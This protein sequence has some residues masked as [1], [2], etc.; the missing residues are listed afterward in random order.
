MKKFIALIASVG[1]F[2]VGCGG[3]SSDSKPDPKNKTLSGYVID[4]PIEGAKVYLDCKEDRY[5][6]KNKTSPNGAF[7]ISYPYSVSPKGCMVYA[8]GGNDG[9]DLSDLVLKT[10]YNLQDKSKDI[11]ITPIT[12]LYVDVGK[13]KQKV[14]EFLDIQETAIAK[15]PTK[16]I[17]L[18]KAAKKLVKI[19]LLKTTDDKKITIQNVDGKKI[20]TYADSLK[21]VSDEDKQDL[22]TT[23]SSIDKASTSQEIIK[24][25]SLP[26]VILLL[27]KAYALSD[28]N[29]IQKSNIEILADKIIEA[30]KKDSKYKTVTK[31]KVR[32][33]LSDIDLIPSFE[34]NGSLKADIVVVLDKPKAVFQALMDSNTSID[35]KDVD[36]IN[37]YNT[38]KYK[39]IL[40]SNEERVQ[41]YT[42]SEKSHIAK[43]LSLIEDTYDDTL[44]NPAYVEIAKGFAKLG[45]AED[46]KKTLKESVYDE[47][48]KIRGGIGIA[49]ILIEQDK[50]TKAKEVL[51]LSYE[52]IK[53]YLVEK[54]ATYLDDKDLELI[55]DLY[56]AYY[57]ADSVETAEALMIFSEQNIIKNFTDPEH[58]TKMINTYVEVMQGLI[59]DNKA[60]DAKTIF[61][62]ATEFALKAKYDEDAP[63]DTISKL[64]YLALYGTVL[65][66][67]KTRVDQL[68][69]R[70]KEIDEKCDTGYTML[71]AKD[72]S[73]SDLNKTAGYNA[74]LIGGIMALNGDLDK[75]LHTMQTDGLLAPPFWGTTPRNQTATAMWSGVAAAMFIDGNET[76]AIN[77]IYKHRIKNQA[78]SGLTRLYMK[79]QV[80]YTLD[81]G[82]LLKIYDNAH[83]T[84]LMVSF[85][86]KLVNDI[87]GRPWVDL[88]DKDIADHVLAYQYLS[89]GLREFGLAIAIRELHE[90]GEVTKRNTIV[91]RAIKFINKMTDPI[92]KVAAYQSIINVLNEIKINQSAEFNTLLDKITKEVKNVEINATYAYSSKSSK[93]RKFEASYRRII[94]NIKYLA[95]YSTQENAKTLINKVKDAI[96][97]EDVTDLKNVMRRLHYAIGI[98]ENGADLYSSSLLATMVEAKDFESAEALI[99]KI[100]NIVENEVGDNL[101]AY[102]LY[103]PIARAYAS[104]NKIEKVNATL[105][106]IKTLEQKKQAI[107]ASIKFLSQYDSF[108]HTA[109]A[110]VDTDGDGKPDFFSLTATKEDITKSKLELDD[111]I[112]G[113]GTKVDKD[114]FPYDPKQ[115]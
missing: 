7:A 44:L 76:E 88:T 27:K 36:G 17:E 55:M 14:A 3:S 101:N 33:A 21:N 108:E 61:K 13:N 87:D 111:D 52:Q 70:A 94:S 72:V 73:D 83:G 16:E 105:K 65:E 19:Y 4:A 80:N 95:R 84:K 86:E 62:R 109:V 77:M 37:L 41:Y 49:N 11:F 79:S 75:V 110:S 92:Y 81:A 42:F 39:K 106:K 53:P 74:G 8:V 78:D 48:D 30:N 67:E 97:K 2:L 69:A 24:Q 10:P 71:T 43:A 59:L 60:D 107:L 68:M 66:D 91:E 47:F 40:K 93:R 50:K 82:K 54:G 98:I 32:K 23:F 29:A 100:D 103:M 58:F 114:N 115:K 1:L 22:N 63:G 64:L 31:H 20:D 38:K 85:Y 46:A 26:S 5:Y 51:D 96:F 56:V 35:I 57:K 90:A 102:K 18:A 9:D 6:G 12:T 104:I 45:Y 89:S 113:D 15:N 28:I 112:D 25:V 34:D 99:D